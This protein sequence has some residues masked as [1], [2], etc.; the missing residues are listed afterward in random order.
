MTLVICPGIHD[1]R[2]SDRFVAAL[3]RQLLAT[4]SNAAKSQPQPIFVM[5]TQ[6]YAPFSGLSVWSYWQGIS[7]PH[8]PLKVI[9][10]SAGVAGAIA[11]IPLWQGQG[12][13]IAVMIAVDGWG[14]PQLG[15]FPFHR[16][17]HDQ[18]THWS[19]ALLGAGQDSFYADPAVAHLDL[20]QS[21]DRATGWAMSPLGDSL[22]Q[23]TAIGFIANLLQRHGCC[24]ASVHKASVHQ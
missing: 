16:V 7:N 19:S 6:R 5:P 21:P 8:L 13:S 14:V 11:A 1:P 24:S 20:W 9:S 10:F 18:F 22:G 17:S 3:T 12:R 15:D 23:T 4:A 2:L